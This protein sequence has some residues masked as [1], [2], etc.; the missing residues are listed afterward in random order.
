MVTSAVYRLAGI[1]GLCWRDA[2]MLRKF[3]ALLTL[4]G[5]LTLAA[6][7][8]AAPQSARQALIEK[9]FGKTPGSLEKH[10]PEVTLRAL[11]QAQPVSAGSMLQGFA[12]LSGQL[13]ANGTQLQTFE[14]GSTLLVVD[15]PRTHGKFEI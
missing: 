1:M 5:A 8:Q 13:S 3:G 9:F 14:T 15:D 4:C 11:K 10:L 2:M 12:L 7:A 6:S